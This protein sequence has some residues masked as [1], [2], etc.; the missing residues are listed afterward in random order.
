MWSWRCRHAEMRNW[1]FKGKQNNRDSSYGIQVKP[2]TD[3]SLFSP[4]WA[5]IAGVWQFSDRAICLWKMGWRMLD[6]DIGSY[7][8]QGKDLGPLAVG[9]PLIRHTYLAQ[10]VPWSIRRSFQCEAFPLHFGLADHCDHPKC[11]WLGCVISG[12][13]GAASA[14][15][16]DIKQKIIKRRKKTKASQ[17]LVLFLD[18]CVLYQK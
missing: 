13:R 4:V 17:S 15:S 12:S 8:W 3:G 1:H 2:L 10:K 5:R 11:G 14:R 7:R 18:H 16:P 6:I 9:R